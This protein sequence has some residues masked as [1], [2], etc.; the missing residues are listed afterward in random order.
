MNFYL[1]IIIITKIDTSEE[2]FQNYHIELLKLIENYKLKY[3]TPDSLKLSKNFVK[4]YSGGPEKSIAM[5][6][7]YVC[8]LIENIK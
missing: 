8:T 6:N 5:E 2:K 1:L 7:I 3:N 4:F